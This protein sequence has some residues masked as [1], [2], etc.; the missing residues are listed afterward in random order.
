[1]A[2]GNQKGRYFCGG[3][4]LKINAKCVILEAGLLKFYRNKDGDPHLSTHSR[5]K[6]FVTPQHFAWVDFTII[7][8]AL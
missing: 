6:D 5:A 3:S 8:Q 4:I 1:M 2:P 7:H